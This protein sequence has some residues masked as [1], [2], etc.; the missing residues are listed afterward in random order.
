MDVWKL[1]RY[2]GEVKERML[3]IDPDKQ[4]TTMGFCQ[5]HPLLLDP[6]IRSVYRIGS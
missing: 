3:R 1:F 2:Q 6:S 5:L 4:V